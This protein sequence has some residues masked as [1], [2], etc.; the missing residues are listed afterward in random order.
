MPFANRLL[1]K[2]ALPE[3]S[4]EPLVQIDRFTAI[5]LGT[6]SIHAVIVD[7]FSD[8]SFRVVDM[9]KEQVGFGSQGLRRLLDEAAMDRAMAALHKIN[10]LSMRREAVH[11]VAYATSAVRESENGGAFLERVLHETGIKVLAIPGIKEAELIQTAVRRAVTIGTKPVL[12]MDIG[13]GSTEF[14]LCDDKRTLFIDSYKLGGSRTF[15][16]FVQSDPLSKED[17][18]RIKEHYRTQLLRLD[19]ALEA[20]RPAQLIVS[21]GTM[22]TAATIILNRRGTNLTTVGNGF[23]FTLDELNALYRDVTEMPREQRLRLPGMDEK[24]VDAIVPGLILTQYIAKKHG[25]QQLVFSSYALREGMVLEHINRLFQGEIQPGE[26]LDLRHQSVFELLKRCQWHEKHSAHVARIALKL[27]DDLQEF[28]GMDANDRELLKFSCLVHDIGYHISQ[29]QHHKH[30]MYLVQNADL[31]GFEP[32]EIDVMALVARYHR[33]SVPKD[34]H[35]EFRR[36]SFDVRQ[37]VVRLAAFMRVAD[38]LDRSH[39]QNIRA[40]RAI[41]NGKNIEIR[42]LPTSDA[43]LEIWG[44]KRKS[45]LFEALF[46]CKLKFREVPALPESDMLDKVS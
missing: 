7:V 31:K 20:N 33:K 2:R 5:D 26:F 1:F 45:E 10:L 36:L 3:R 4:G 38:G 27:F 25:I 46:E 12:I 29:R 9:L 23:I 16:A 43:E 22:E 34:K 19:A 39:Y 17:K 11:T 8:G 32:D 28:H 24:R 6:N 21:S 44:A 35:D 37:K 15:A 18:A 40:V 42:L 30:S 41:H 14:I 13:G